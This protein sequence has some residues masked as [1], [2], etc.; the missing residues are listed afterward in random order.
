MIYEGGYGTEKRRAVSVWISVLLVSWI[1]IFWPVPSFA[2]PIYGIHVSS[3]R[4]PE[5]AETEVADYLARGVEAY[6]VYETIPDKGMW[7]RV[8]LGRFDSYNKA[9]AAGQRLMTR[10]A[11][12]YYDIGRVDAA[13]NGRYTPLKAKSDTFEDDLLYRDQMGAQRTRQGTFEPIET[14]PADPEEAAAIKRRLYQGAPNVAGPRT[15][16][17]VPQGPVNQVSPRGPVNQAAPQGRYDSLL[18]RP[19]VEASPAPSVPNRVPAGPP[20]PA[21]QNGRFSDPF[22]KIPPD[23]MAQLK[24]EPDEEKDWSEDSIFA[25]YAKLG[26]AFWPH[27]SDFKVTRTT[28][29]TLDRWFIDD[30]DS[31]GFHHALV[32]SL[33]V[34]EFLY[35]DGSIEKELA[36]NLDFWYLTLGPRAA[37]LFPNEMAL[38]IKNSLVIGFFDWSGLP[39]DFG[40]GLGMDWGLGVDYYMGRLNFGA[41]LLYRWISYD[42]NKPGGVVA[43]SDSIDFSGFI[44]SGSIGYQF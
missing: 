36:N 12:D 41:E 26:M 39:G 25:L 24:E 44:F 33:R 16:P 6:A 43:S 23:V 17:Y 9:M 4:S 20:E 19:P 3:F 10:G 38:Y 13:L 8:Y 42:Y 28:A 34:W 31:R 5:N 14:A 30:N 40:T 15:R 37:F 35:L 18:D 22:A 29:T 27:G 32:G 7:Y 2:R 1:F 21:V 11:I